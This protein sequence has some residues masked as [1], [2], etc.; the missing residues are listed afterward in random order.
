MILLFAALLA[1]AAQQPPAGA[2]TEADVAEGRICD[3][4]GADNDALLAA[5]RQRPSIITLQDDGEFIQ[6][7]DPGEQRI[8]TFTIRGHP[9]WP[10]ISCS[11][12]Q[13]RDGRI[14]FRQSLVCND[15]GRNAC[16]AFF[17]INRDRNNRI[18]AAIEALAAQR[19]E[20]RPQQEPQ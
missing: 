10:A 9:A 15:A 17:A 16:L 13:W 12:W 1:V 6:L 2:E 8:W 18:R 11:D 5:I 19:R 4:N 20:S 14:G 7:V 3:R